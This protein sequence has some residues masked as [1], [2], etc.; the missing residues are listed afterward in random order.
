MTTP[1]AANTPRRFNSDF[2]VGSVAKVLLFLTV[3]G[4]VLWVTL[5]P[6][7]TTSLNDVA[8]RLTY[9]RTWTAQTVG[10]DPLCASEAA[11][12]V[13]TLRSNH[14]EPI[15]LR[16]RENSYD[17]DTT[18]GEEDTAYWGWAQSTL[19]AQPHELNDL[20]IN[21][22]IGDYKTSEQRYQYQENGQPAYALVILL[23]RDRRH[24]LQIEFSARTPEAL[25]AAQP[26]IEAMIAS[27]QI[28]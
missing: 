9:P 26:D 25:A 20:D 12:C 2:V 4:A 5:N 27:L 15:R 8:L 1:P 28:R 18:L 10:Q 7:T 22:S 11:R 14:D 21:T 19:S 6:S 24:L 16:I 17:F 3:V 23:L 13:A